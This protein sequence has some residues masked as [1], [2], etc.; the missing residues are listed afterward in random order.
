MAHIVCMSKMRYSLSASTSAFYHLEEPHFCI[1]PVALFSSC[2]IAL[3]ND[4]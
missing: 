2:T 1:L 3:L 4:E